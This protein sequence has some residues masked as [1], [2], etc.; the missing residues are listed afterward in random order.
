[1]VDINVHNNTD[2]VHREEKIIY[3]GI[4]IGRGGY[5]FCVLRLVRSNFTPEIE[6]QIIVT[7]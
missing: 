3:I 1:M 5:G 2:W 7:Q 4:R 6:Y